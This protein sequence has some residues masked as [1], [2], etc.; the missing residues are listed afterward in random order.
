MDNIYDDVDDEYDGSPNDPDLGFARPYSW[1]ESSNNDQYE[2][3]QSY[4]YFPGSGPVVHEGFVPQN[5]DEDEDLDEEL[6][7]QID[8]P[9]DLQGHPLGRFK[10][11]EDEDVTMDDLPSAPVDD[12]SED[13]DFDPLEEGN[14]E[15]S[16]ASEMESGLGSEDSDDFASEPGRKSG[17]ARGRPRGDVQGIRGGRGGR[18]G[19]RRGPRKPVEPSNEFKL[20]QSKATNAFIG[21]DFDKA[22]EFA[23]KAI[24]V[25]SEI[26][27]PYSLLSEI[28]LAKGE[29]QASLTVLM[30]GA[31]TKPKDTSLWWK[32]VRLTLE[33]AGGDR[34]PF[35]EQLLQ[36]YSQIIRANPKDMEARYGRAAINR[37]LGYSGRAAQ[38]YEQMIKLEPHD[39]NIL[40]HIA[41][42]YIDM[43][44][45]GRALA[46]YQKAIPYF[47]SAEN[48]EDADFDW[49][50]INIYVELFG[51]LERYAEGIFELKSL[52]RWLLGRQDENYWDTVEQDDREWDYEDEPRRVEI[53]E[54]QP[55]EY[56]KTEYGEG[57]PLELRVKMGMYRLKLGEGQWAEALDHFG[58]LEPEQSEPGAKVFDYPD[59]FRDVA[60]ALSEQGLYDEAL[61]FYEPLQQVGDYTD[62][63]FYTAMAQCYRAAGL[64]SEAEE[65]YQ[66]I[67]ENDADNINARVQ[68]AKMYEDLGRSEEAF[69]YVNEV[70]LLGRKDIA[71]QSIREGVSKVTTTEELAALIP[72]I[73]PNREKSKKRQGPSQTA[74]AKQERERIRDENVEVLY[75]R[76]QA[77]QDSMRAGDETAMKEWM[78]TARE[79]TDE[80]RTCK[81]LF[82]WDK[83]IKFL[84][85]SA[86]ARKRAL[87]PKNSEA[88][89]EVEAMAGRLQE[90]LNREEDNGQAAE[91]QPIPQ[92]YRGIPFDVWLDIFLEYAICTAKINKVQDAYEILSAA[93]DANVF[94]HSPESMFMIHTCWF[95]C[96][97]YANDEETMCTIAR[98]F[99]KE[100]NSATD[101]YRLFGALNR[102]YRGQGSWY[103]AGP[104]QKF[105][106]RQVKAMD[107]ALVG[108]KKKEAEYQERTSNA[109]KDEQGEPIISDEMDTSLLMLYGSMLYAG[110]SYAFA[111]NYFYRAYA[112]D[113][114]NP[115]INLLLALSYIH[116]GL[117]RQADNR[118][119]LIMQGFSFLFTYYDCHKA[120][121]LLQLQQEAEFNVARAF[122][123]LGLNHLAIPY[124][125]RCLELS[126][127]IQR[128]HAGDADEAGRRSDPEDFAPEAALALQGIF[129]LSGQTDQAKRITD[130]WLVI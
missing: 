94:Y 79:L 104:S 1:W 14:A 10:P 91:N 96:A 100:Y 83:Y 59:L 106:L 13:P 9:V 32:I 116:Y 8:V 51:F 25:N 69:H 4:G 43:E 53:S 64:T 39:T 80:F 110:A 125:E 102:L 2:H 24:H 77:V 7:A 81:T 98:W 75:V 17:G 120:S 88:M 115:T 60:D 20:L 84:G 33:R 26:F 12:S 89:D 16:N 23:L 113:P 78:A 47:R 63:A 19:G 129:Y 126:E 74:A 21:Y 97:L 76:L 103:N 48:V 122:H 34:S 65:C 6:D 3:D 41:E 52:S 85:Y 46:H 35:Y 67:I 121:P 36:C 5:D 49:S 29:K 95:T 71:N 119:Y 55:G 70:I 117:K 58:W 56:D 37:E 66:T 90:T 54:F 108:D 93:T 31:V 114:A 68:L 18:R 22:T 73:L 27:A 118:H 130:R 87:K 82:P 15:S 127:K 107:F 42:V 62:A 112:L 123:M 44:Q 109:A 128:T 99:M 92:D 11:E 30:A 101:T 45:A 124:Y 38:E 105:V 28:H 72:T 40:R 86:E 111:L 61:R 57:L 50:D